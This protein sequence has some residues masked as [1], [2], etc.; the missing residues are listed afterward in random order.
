MPK[1][2]IYLDHHAT[3]P[4]DP[5][6]W[7]AML[8][9]FGIRFGNAAS[10]H[11]AY[12]WE[13]EAAVKRAREQVAALFGAEPEEIIWTSCA[14]ESINLALKGFC[15][16]QGFDRARILTTNLEHKA[17]LDTCQY[18]AKKGVDVAFLPNNPGGLVQLHK[19]PSGCDG[20]ATLVSAIHANN[21]IGTIQDVDDLIAFCHD[22]GHI[23]HLDAAQSFGKVPFNARR[24][25]FDLASVSAHKLYGPKGVGAIYVRK[26]ARRVRLTPLI[27]GGGHER[28]F[29]SGTLN[30]P[31][32]VGFGQAAEI[33]ARRM[34]VD[35][36]RVRGLR[37][38]LLERL[39]QGL[40]D[41]EVNGDLTHRL[42]GNLN[43]S[44]AGVESESLIMAME[45]VAISNGSACS[46]AKIEPSHVL[47]AC[48]YDERRA[49]S[50]I[51]IGLGRSTSEADVDHAAT[52]IIKE[53]KRLRELQAWV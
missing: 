33:A 16:H 21:E 51:R 6:V 43:V 40:G 3:T 49:Y 25:A 8:P 36:E 45:D 4:L 23:L 35:G 27:H 46:S 17:T 50:S 7:E 38:E 26:R 39:R 48:G 47:L 2:P 41:V 31:A 5:E 28:G 53:A 29:R 19:A 37:D 20:R 34:A 42:D 1:A 10:R 32:I 14:T 9:Y 44:I 13:A 22:G 24:Q 15:E 30:V 18:L 52:R 12:G 11:H